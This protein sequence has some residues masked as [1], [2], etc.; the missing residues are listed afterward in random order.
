MHRDVKLG[1]ALGILVIG[2]AA[3]FCFPRRPPTDI[4]LTPVAGPQLAIADRSIRD[5]RVRTFVAEELEPVRVPTPADLPPVVLETPAPAADSPPPEPIVAAAEPASEAPATIAGVHAPPADA[6]DVLTPDETRLY[7][8]QPGD[9]LSAIAG[10]L[11]GSHRKYD[12]LYQANRDQMKTPNSL[13]PG[14]VLRIPDASPGAGVIVVERVAQRT[15]QAGSK[16][17]SP[18]AIMAAEEPQTEADAE[19][20][21]AA[22][23]DGMADGAAAGEGSAAP[24]R[25]GRFRRAANAPFL[26]A[27]GAGVRSNSAS[28]AVAT[29]SD[30][31]GTGPQAAR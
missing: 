27:A 15:E 21:P 19:L 9:T 16:S 7:T 28:P 11:L 30:R 23:L 18:A 31:L 26:N 29:D 1:L 24:D 14:M 6:D 17:E 10:R 13:Q 22:D 2:F 4:A 5:L 20:E 12:V 8:V 3:A 25:Q